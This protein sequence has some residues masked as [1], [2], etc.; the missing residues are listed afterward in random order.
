MLMDENQ[1]KIAAILYE[2]EDIKKR[3]ALKTAEAQGAAVLFTNLGK[4]LSENPAY[5]SFRGDEIPPE[6][7]SRT[8]FG[9]FNDSDFDARR[10]RE[11]TK[12]IR[13]LQLELNRLTKQRTDLGYPV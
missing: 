11:L 10:I 1:T 2:Y 12:Q 8:P 4:A 5:V 3:L 6:V 9:Q 7:S 13:D